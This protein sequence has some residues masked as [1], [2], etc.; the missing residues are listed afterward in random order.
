L[1]AGDLLPLDRGVGGRALLAFDSEQ[2]KLHDEI[3][4]NKLISSVT[5]RKSVSPPSPNFEGNFRGNVTEKIGSK[6]LTS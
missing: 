2:G 4:K 6:A 5:L 1:R 3:R